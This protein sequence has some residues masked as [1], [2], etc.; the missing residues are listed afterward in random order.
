MSSQ[1][2]YVFHEQPDG[3]GLIT[4]READPMFYDDRMIPQPVDQYPSG[5]SSAPKTVDPIGIKTPSVK[6]PNIQTESI[7][8][9]AQVDLPFIEGN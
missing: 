5:G 6:Q 4:F 1:S 3:L 8:K 7:V 9:P 2:S